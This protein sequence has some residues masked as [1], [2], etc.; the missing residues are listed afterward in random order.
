MLDPFKLEQ[1]YQTEKIV[2]KALK[3]DRRAI[4]ELF[5]TMPSLFQRGT[6]TNTILDPYLYQANEMR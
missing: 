3:G 4:I 2:T 5:V 1:I 6:R